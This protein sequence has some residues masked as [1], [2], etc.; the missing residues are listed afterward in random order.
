MIALCYRTAKFPRFFLSSRGER[1]VSEIYFRV[2]PGEKEFSIQEGMIP[3]I[4]LEAE[5]ENGKA[6]QQLKQKL[7]EIT[8][9]KPGIV[10]GARSRR[11]KL[12]FGQEEDVVRSKI[13]DY[14]EKVKN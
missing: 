3:E 12:V 2:R 4:S 14:S 5:A 10:S 8:G 13:S 6:N 9:E 1:A 11:K 7:E